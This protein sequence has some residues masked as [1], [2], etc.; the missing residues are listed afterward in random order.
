MRFLL[1]LMGILTLTKNLTYNRR[2]Y[3]NENKR[4]YYYIFLLSE[5]DRDNNPFHNRFGA[6]IS[7][8]LKLESSGSVSIE[9]GVTIAKPIE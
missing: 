4:N 6:V 3:P 9:N 8:R 2:S 7:E 1:T 5:K